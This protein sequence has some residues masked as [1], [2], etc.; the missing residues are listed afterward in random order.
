MFFLPNHS[1]L[2]KIIISPIKLLWHLCLKK[3]DCWIICSYRLC[4]S[5]LCVCFEHPTL[6]HSYYSLKVLKLDSIN[7]LTLFFFK[8]FF[9]FFVG[10]GD[11]LSLLYFNT[12]FIICFL[13]PTEKSLIWFSLGLYWICW[14]IWVKLPY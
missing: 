9:F 10:R 3:K 8:V 6:F 12:Y 1:S 14:S 2:L 5:V 7:Y 4:V 11:I 13:I